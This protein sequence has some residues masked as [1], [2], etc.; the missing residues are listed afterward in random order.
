MQIIPSRNIPQ[1]KTS[2]I[3]K[4]MKK[5]FLPSM[6]LTLS[7]ILGDIFSEFTE[8]I[9]QQQNTKYL[10]KKIKKNELSGIAR[11]HLSVYNNKT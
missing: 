9:H 4:Y 2:I 7:L 8:E 11:F 5:E 1:H 6:F 3:T 10:E